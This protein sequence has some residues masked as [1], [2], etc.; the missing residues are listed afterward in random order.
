MLVV[1]KGKLAM[2]AICIATLLAAV[3]TLVLKIC[4]EAGSTFEV[5]AIVEVQPATFTYRPAG[6]FLRDGKP[7]N[8]PTQTIAIDRPL[9]IMKHQVTAA[10]YQRCVDAGACA[11]LA[12][13]IAVDDHPAVQVS[14]RDAEAYA[15]WL[16]RK[17]H[18]HYRLPSD[19]E[20][21]FAAGALFRDDALSNTDASDPAQR[22][23]AKYDWESNS[24]ALES[25]RGRLPIAGVAVNENGLFDVAGDVWEWTNTCFVRQALNAKLHPIGEPIVNCGVRVVEGRH[26]TY[27]SDFIRDA[28]AGGCAVG[29]P[30]T[31]LGFRLVRGDDDS[32]HVVRSLVQWM[33]SQA[34]GRLASYRVD[35]RDV[36]R[37]AASY[38]DRIPQWREAG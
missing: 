11:R 16:S 30:P 13:N 38:V 2:F 33:L 9:P 34:G 29:T 8:P 22:W 14:W 18:V 20:W 31:N 6:D 7:A 3:S 4:L 10:E 23:L 37:R 26:R 35:N 5:P 36:S 1:L 28:R 21:A 24:D 12:P 17:T 19:Q 27:I 15:T 32:L 25:D